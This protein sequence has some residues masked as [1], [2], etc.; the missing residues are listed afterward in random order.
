MSAPSILDARGNPLPPVRRKTQ[1]PRARIRS[2][3]IRTAAGYVGAAL[4]RR[5][6]RNWDPSDGSGDAIALLDLPELRRR[7]RDLA[8]NNPLAG[9]AINSNVTHVVGTGLSVQP[10]IDREYLGLTE[11]EADAWERQALR[12]WREWKDECDVARTLTFDDAQAQVLRG[13]LEGGDIFALKRFLPRPGT[14]VATRIQLVEAERVSN[15]NNQPDTT[16]LAGGVEVDRYGAPVRYWVSSH[17]PGDMWGWAMQDWT[18]MP[19]FSRRTGERMTLHLFT[20]LRPGQRR[21]IPYLAPVI[22]PLRGIGEYTDAELTA[23]VLTSFLTVFIKS[24]SGDPD[25]APLAITDHEDTAVDD[26]EREFSLGPGA[27]MHLEPDEEIET[28]KSDRPNAAFDPFVQAFFRLVGVGLELP[29]EVLIKHF[30][31]SYSA[32]R[33]ALLE[34]WQFWSTRRAWLARGFCQPCYGWVIGEAVMRGLIAAPGFFT[35]PLA[36]RAWLGARWIGPAPGQIDPLKEARA[37][38]IRIDEGFSTLEEEVAAYS[39]GDWEAVHEQRAKEV[40]MR[41][42]AG[43]ISE[44]DSVSVSDAGT[45][46]AEREE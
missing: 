13:A 39:G 12:I 22:E 2:A 24:A 28:V 7:S 21:G 40:R 29:Y 36:R 42:E 45:V 27:F 31:S 3:A 38:Q 4:D 33:A 32:A 46:D 41:R 6:T 25:E 9:G 5:M 43:L 30:T 1:I 10:T 18:P 44:R 17:H 16:Q 26:P 11:E 15:P 37:A 14:L 23:T 8:R 35:D 34:A 20:Q 19:A